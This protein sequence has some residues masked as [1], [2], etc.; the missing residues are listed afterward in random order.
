MALILVVDDDALVAETIGIHLTG[1]GHEV[2]FAAH[3]GDALKQLKR[4]AVDL[5]VTDI[6]MP[7]VEGI[8]F[9][10]AARLQGVKV[11]IIAMS[12]GSVRDARVGGYD[13]LKMALSLGATRTL[14][15]PF[16][17]VQFLDEVN[18]CLNAANA[19]KAGGEADTR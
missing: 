9:I 4:R 7:E 19:A 2:V 6:L 14:S 18:G 8:G 1:A 3:G 11:P 17:R 5:V 10:R 15:K 13:Y 12:G 16:G